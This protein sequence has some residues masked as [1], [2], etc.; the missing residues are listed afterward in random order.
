MSRFISIS[1]PHSGDWCDLRTDGSHATTPLSGQTRVAIARRHA[2]STSST[3]TL[4][5]DMIVA[6]RAAGHADLL[7]YDLLGDTL[8]NTDDC[9]SRHHEFCHAWHA[10]IGAVSLHT[11][12]LGDLDKVTKSTSPLVSYNST[13]ATD[14]V[15]PGGGPG[16][17]D[18][19][20]EAKEV[21]RLTPLAK[22]SHL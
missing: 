7:K 5:Y 9:N 4:L 8:C 13:H 17:S 14:I 6:A 16:G 12:L 10:A 19:L 18:R 22:S 21:S 1:Q 3:P 2:G 15:E 20:F 11:V